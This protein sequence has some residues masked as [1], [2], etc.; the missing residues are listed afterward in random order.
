MDCAGDEEAVIELVE[1]ELPQRQVHA[2]LRMLVCDY[3]A[4]P[5][6]APGTS[7][8]D[9]L[10]VVTVW[11]PGPIEP[12][13]LAEGSRLLLTGA[14]VSSYRGGSPTAAELHLSIRPTAGGLRPAPADPRL[15]ACSRYRRRATLSVDEL[16]HAAAGQ[17]VDVAGEVEHCCA[18]AAGSQ[19]LVLRLR[20]AGRDGSVCFADIEFPRC[21][22]GSL[23]PGVG[24]VVTVRNCR[25]LLPA[26]DG[27]N[28]DAAVPRLHAGDVAEFA[29]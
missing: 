13:D 20:G 5:Y 25:L 26:R 3:P 7:S 19:M 6:R 16:Q 4:R 14:A 24:S 28:D 17:E 22:F 1:H 2:L 15:V 12:A 29:L 8:A 21:V 18:A 9:A 27:D 10:A 11:R 23:S